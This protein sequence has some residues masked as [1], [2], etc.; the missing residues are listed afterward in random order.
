MCLFVLF[1]SVGGGWVS[2][3]VC[4]FIGYCLK[5]HLMVALESNET[6]ETHTH[7]THTLEI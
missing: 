7:N 2:E 5:L 1:V 4:V 3:C 6:T